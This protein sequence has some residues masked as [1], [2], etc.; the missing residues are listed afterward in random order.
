ML[1]QVFLFV[2]NGSHSLRSILL[3]LMGCLLLDEARTMDFI[4][5]VKLLLHEFCGD[6]TFSGL[7]SMSSKIVLGALDFL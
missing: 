7:V 1:F 4:V 6:P 5:F 3:F 2:T